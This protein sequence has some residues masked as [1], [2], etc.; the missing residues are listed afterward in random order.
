MPVMDGHEF[1]SHLD[2]KPADPY[3]V[4][5]LTAY[6][7]VNSIKSAYDAGVTTFLKK[8]FNLFEIRGVVRNSI[9]IKQLSTHLDEMVQERTVELEQ[10]LREITALNRF[11][12]RHLEWR[13][14]L[15]AKYQ[16]VVE[17]L[18]RL[19]TDIALLAQRAQSESV[20]S[21]TEMSGFDAEH[22]DTSEQ[23]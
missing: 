17:E 12:Q 23:E 4:V 11:F 22:F 19:D 10:R 1:L 2:L 3:S 8:P 15:D 13:S 21:L 5:V 16:D 20:S 18:G 7:D 9:A 14:V 6:S